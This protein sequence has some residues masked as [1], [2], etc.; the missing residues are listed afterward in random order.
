[1]QSVEAEQEA[2]VQT[3]GIPADGRVHKLG[4]FLTMTYQVLRKYY[5]RAPDPSPLLLQTLALENSVT[6]EEAK[7]QK[8]GVYFGW[9]YAAA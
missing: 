9:F 4:E 3:K 8:G 7:Q 1:M 5:K 2:F 6:S